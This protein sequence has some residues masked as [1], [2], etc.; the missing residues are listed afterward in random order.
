[1]EVDGFLKQKPDNLD[2][3]LIDVHMNL[4]RS[5]EITEKFGVE[6]ESPQVIL[7][8]DNGNVLWHASHYLIKKH[9]IIQAIKENG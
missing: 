4:E 5:G 7:V 9:A 3:E 6:H 2:F 1:M 8:D